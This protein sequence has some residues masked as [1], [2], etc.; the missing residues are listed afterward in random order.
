MRTQTLACVSTDRAKKTTSTGSWS[1][2]TIGHTRPRIFY[3]V[4]THSSH[5]FCW[6]TTHHLGF[7]AWENPASG[8]EHRKT[9]PRSSLESAWTFLINLTWIF[10]FCLVSWPQ[11]HVNIM[12]TCCSAA[13]HSR[14]VVDCAHAGQLSCM[15]SNRWKWIICSKL[16]ISGTLNKYHQHS[17]KVSTG[18]IKA[19]W[20]ECFCGWRKAAQQR[21]ACT[22]SGSITITECAADYLRPGK[23]G[24]FV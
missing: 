17:F 4:E 24:L 18:Q 3:E 1:G 12:H 10:R 22:Q 20:C 21:C 8:W 5:S 9:S 7:L 15:K 11:M 16:T 13:V 2:P 23:A 6:A 14:P 19:A